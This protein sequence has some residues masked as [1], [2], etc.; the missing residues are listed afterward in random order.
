MDRTVVND[1]LLESLNKTPF[2]RRQAGGSND[3]TL[4]GKFTRNMRLCG[5]IIMCF[6]T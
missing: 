5:F 1:S 2:L 6:L 3:D 4:Y